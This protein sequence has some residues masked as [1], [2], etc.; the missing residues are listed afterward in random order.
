MNQGRLSNNLLKTIGEPA[1]YAL[2]I[3][4]DFKINK[5]IIKYNFKI[6]CLEIDDLP[7]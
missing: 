1:G 3:S 5:F 6:E 2:V 7:R 4:W